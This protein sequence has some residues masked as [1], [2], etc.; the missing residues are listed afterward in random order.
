[1]SPRSVY[2]PTGADLAPEFL[3]YADVNPY[4]A[5]LSEASTAPSAVG[6]HTK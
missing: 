1:M 5:F 6:V 4:A 3:Y 2:W